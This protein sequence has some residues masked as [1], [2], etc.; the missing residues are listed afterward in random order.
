MVLL[1]LM[2]GLPGSGKT[3]LAKKLEKERC[4][5]RLCPDEWIVALYGEDIAR[6]R[7]RLYAVRDPV[8]ALQWQLAEQALAREVDVILESGF[9]SRR[10]RDHMRARAKELNATVELHF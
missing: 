9:W 1:H 8:E 10:E 6:D 4:A 5:L 2:C 7:D 3:T